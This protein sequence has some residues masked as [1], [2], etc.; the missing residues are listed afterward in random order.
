MRWLV[1][2]GLLFT[3]C[4]TTLER[5]PAKA[6][7]VTDDIARFW[8]AFDEGTDA[9]TLD[10][11]YLARGSPSLRAFVERRIGSATRLSETV[12][13]NKAYY[14]SIRANTL[15][16]ATPEFRNT[17]VD[18]FTRAKALDPDA[19]FPPTALLIGRM[20][21][22]GT[23]SREG[24]LVGLELFTAAPNSPTDTF[25][26]FERAATKSATDLLV[27][28]IAHEHAHVLQDLQNQPVGKTLLEQCVME[29]MADFIGERVAGRLVDESMY[30]WARAREADLWA[31]FQRERDGTDLS[32]CLYN[33]GKAPQRP[34]DLGYFIGYRVAQAYA[35]RFKD[36][37]EATRTLLRAKSLTTLAM[38]SGYDGKP[39]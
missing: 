1:A 34:G 14:A 13:R 29:G 22:G 19:A 10:R 35:K 27:P 18:A 37:A 33:Q 5:D 38:E 25:D 3:A 21:S 12:T 32:S 16:V 23:T 20:S 36:D 26:D 9:A 24:I 7:L 2:L 11:R 17:L 8:E 6:P 4:G 39:P 30:A 28:L 31:E 15:S